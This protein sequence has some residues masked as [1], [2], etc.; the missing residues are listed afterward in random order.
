MDARL[1]Q[2]YEWGARGSGLCV[3]ARRVL[4]TPASHQTQNPYYAT[5][6]AHT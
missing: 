2:H 6:V 5:L 4:G 1:Q 3:H